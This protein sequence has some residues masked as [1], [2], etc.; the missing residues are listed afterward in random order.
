MVKKHTATKQNIKLQVKKGIGDR[1]RAIVTFSMYLQS[2]KHKKVATTNDWSVENYGWFQ[3]NI[4]RTKF[5]WYSQKSNGDKMH[6]FFIPK[7]FSTEKGKKTIL[8]LHSIIKNIKW[9]C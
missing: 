2:S 4:P 1:E 5:K 8:L 9:I 7:E 3:S 6:R